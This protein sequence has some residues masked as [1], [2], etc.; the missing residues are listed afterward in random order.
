MVRCMGPKLVLRAS[1]PQ[2]AAPWAL[3]RAACRLSQM[4]DHAVRPPAASVLTS[5]VWWAVRSLPRGRPPLWCGGN[6]STTGLP[7]GVLSTLGG[8]GPG[9]LVR[10]VD[11][12]LRARPW[13]P[14]PCPR[15]GAHVAPVGALVARGDRRTARWAP[16]Y[17]KA[18]HRVEVGSGPVRIRL[19][20]LL[21]RL[22]GAACRR[23]G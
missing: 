22:P 11:R 14:A 1:P 5:G 13:P 3:C 19:P 2:I 16:R 9:L 12:F 23:G 4:P 7:A 20:P 17:S 15:P 21:W 6:L 10:C 8:P 18:R